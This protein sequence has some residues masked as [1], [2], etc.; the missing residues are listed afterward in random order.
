MCITIKRI[1]SL[2]KKIIFHKRFDMYAVS[3]L[4]TLAGSTSERSAYVGLLAKITKNINNH[5]VSRVLS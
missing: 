5:V 2:K 1:E 4:A 3:G